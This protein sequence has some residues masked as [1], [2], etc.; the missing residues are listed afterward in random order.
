ME[1]KSI[2]FILF[3]LLFFINNKYNIFKRF[4]YVK[5]NGGVR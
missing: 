3:S 1:N 4:Y 5:N 2:Y